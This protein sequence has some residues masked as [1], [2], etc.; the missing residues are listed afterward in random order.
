MHHAA[1]GRMTCWLCL[2]SRDTRAV[3]MRTSTPLASQFLTRVTIFSTGGPMNS[4]PSARQRSSSVLAK[5]PS[6]STPIQGFPIIPPSYMSNLPA[7]NS[8][9]SLQITD[10]FGNSRSAPIDPPSHQN[11]LQFSH[12]HLL[13][14]QVLL[15]AIPSLES[16]V[17]PLLLVVGGVR[18]V[19]FLVDPPRA[20]QS[21]VEFLPVIRRENEYST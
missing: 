7:F 5:V 9:V 11:L 6:K 16:V 13:I 20:N 4:L 19:H 21:G 1:I 8:P 15:G 14:V 17:Q 2:S 18:H 10:T 12:R 3:T